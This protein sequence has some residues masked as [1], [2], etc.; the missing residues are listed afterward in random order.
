M[1]SLMLMRSTIMTEKLVRR[2]TRIPSEYEADFLDQVM[3]R[4]VESR[5]IV[6][7]QADN[8]VEEV[9]DWMAA[10]APGSTHQGFPVLEATGQLLGVVTRRDLL[11]PGVPM[12][13][14]VRGIIKRPAVVIFE[15]N[16]LRDAAD[17]MVRENVGRLPI[18]SRENLHQVIGIITRSDLLGAHERRMRMENSA[19]RT[20][21]FSWSRWAG[22]RP[23]G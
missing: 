4:D 23:P 6:V 17:Q 13:C 8:A 16:S 5:E 9:R 1:V 21:V 20:I 14:L 11:D 19:Q 10:R 12:A 22:K 15:D 2:G 18:V 7:L 3:V